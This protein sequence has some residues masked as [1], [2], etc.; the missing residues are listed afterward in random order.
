MNALAQRDQI[1]QFLLAVAVLVGTPL[2]VVALVIRGIVKRRRELARWRECAARNG[3][4]QG[5]GSALLSGTRNGLS[6]TLGVEGSEEDDIVWRAGGL[7]WS[8]PPTDAQLRDDA[9]ICHRAQATSMRERFPLRL[10]TFGADAGAL[11]IS[12]RN[13][14]LNCEDA[15]ALVTFGLAIARHPRVTS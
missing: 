8:Q 7:T 6:W 2:T 4:S 1:L 9:A 10:F 3:W 14:A 12:L 15:E 5:P 13:R 11:T